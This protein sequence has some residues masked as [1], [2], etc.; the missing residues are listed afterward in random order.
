[1]N[2]YENFDI[3]LS[4][5]VLKFILFYFEPVILKHLINIFKKKK[6]IEKYYYQFTANK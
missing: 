6:N 4:I 3:I 2:A 1:M 5:P